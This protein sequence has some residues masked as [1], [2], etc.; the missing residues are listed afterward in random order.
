MP[1]NLRR[2]GPEDPNK[3]NVNQ[4]YEIAYWTQTLG[5]SETVLRS[6]VRNVGPMVVDVRQWL[7]ANKHV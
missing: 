4:A 6:A 1:D 2:R 5:V 7:R 3:I